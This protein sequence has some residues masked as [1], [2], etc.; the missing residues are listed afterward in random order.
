MS[1]AYTRPRITYRIFNI[2]NSDP[3]PLMDFITAIEASLGMS[4]QKNFL[5]L[6]AGDVT[7]TF[8][9]TRALDAWVGFQP[10]TSVRDGVGRFVDWYRSY[11]GC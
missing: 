1:M 2:G 9:D 8:A 6:Q 7:E 3:V 10:S 11:Y 5:P 4:A